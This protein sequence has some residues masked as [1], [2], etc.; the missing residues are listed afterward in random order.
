LDFPQRDRECALRRFRAGKYVGRRAKDCGARRSNRK[1]GVVAPGEDLGFRARD[2]SGRL[3]PFRQ[4]SPPCATRPEPGRDDCRTSAPRNP[5]GAR[6]CESDDLTAQL[7]VD[8][9]TTSTVP[10]RIA[11]PE[12][13]VLACYGC[14]VGRCRRVRGHAER[15]S[16]WK[17][18]VKRAHS[19]EHRASIATI[20]S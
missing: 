6:R 4:S 12:T 19:A 15:R 18:S 3:C 7:S 8:R 13:P 5:T 11:I 16:R 2:D 20:R 1:A 17:R 9:P 10:K 14:G